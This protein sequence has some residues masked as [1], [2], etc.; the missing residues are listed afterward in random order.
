MGPGSGSGSRSGLG[1][2]F[3]LQP[4]PPHLMP[5]RRLLFG[6]F[7]LGQPLRRLRPPPRRPPRSPAISISPATSRSPAVSRRLARLRRFARRALIS[8]SISAS[9]SIS[10]SRAPRAVSRAPR[11][12]LAPLLRVAAAG[13]EAPADG[14][15]PRAV[16][17]PR[18]RLRGDGCEGGEAAAR[19]G[20]WPQPAVAGDEPPAE[21]HP[22]AHE[23]SGCDGA[24]SQ[25]VRVRVRVVVARGHCRAQRQWQ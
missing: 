20:G 11:A 7:V 19:E 1:L 13:A 16:E 5:L 25:S 4:P 8:T 22:P 17:I 9:I 21:Y 12:R 18:R 2:G 6:A 23:G 3:H 14:A 15:E 24:G 10:I